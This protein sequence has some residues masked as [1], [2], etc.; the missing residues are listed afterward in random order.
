MMVI[1][2]HFAEYLSISELLKAKMQHCLC[3]EPAGRF[4]K[5]LRTPRTDLYFSK[6]IKTEMD[7]NA[8][9]SY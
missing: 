1:L 4:L 8:T 3:K 6:L 7:V 9:T 2:F 5:S